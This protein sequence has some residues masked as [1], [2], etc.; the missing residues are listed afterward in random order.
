MITVVSGVI[1][2]KAVGGFTAY[3]L[4]KVTNGRLEV[5]GEHKRADNN[6]TQVSVDYITIVVN[7]SWVWLS[8]FSRIG[9]ALQ[10]NN[11]TTL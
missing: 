6:L 9:E 2:E 10:L 7:A 5:G 4:V 3:A 11:T 1:S 8:Q